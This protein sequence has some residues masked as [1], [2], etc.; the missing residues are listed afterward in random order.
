[1]GGNRTNFRTRWADCLK[2]KVKV[3]GLCP[4]T[5]HLS[6]GKT[7]MMALAVLASAKIPSILVGF[8]LMEPLWYEH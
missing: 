1:M 3:T 4:G 5:G 7:F 8:C 6:V 2:L